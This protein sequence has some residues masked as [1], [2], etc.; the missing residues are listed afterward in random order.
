MLC[1][2]SSPSSA[3][4]TSPV[5][6]LNRILMTIG[7]EASNIDWLRSLVRQGL[8]R[9]IVGTIWWF[10]G[11]EVMQVGSEAHLWCNEWC[12][13]S[14]SKWLGVIF[15]GM[16]MS[17]ESVSW[18]NPNQRLAPDSHFLWVYVALELVCSNAWNLLD[19]LLLIYLLLDD[20]KTCIHNSGWLIGR[21]CLLSRSGKIVCAQACYHHWGISGFWKSCRVS[22][23]CQRSQLCHLGFHW[24]Y[25]GREI[26]W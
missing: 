10:A 3:Y 25:P 12:C 20:E 9:F 7:P 8:W 2:N 19:G 18:V 15:S 13:R 5:S 11:V 26:L 6:Y 24:M 1:Y 4:I 23:A 17:C 21:S 22:V 16:S 14:L